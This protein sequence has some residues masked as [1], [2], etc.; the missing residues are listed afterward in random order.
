PSRF[1]CARRLGRPYANSQL[2]CLDMLQ[3]RG[4]HSCER[5]P[6]FVLNE[7]ASLGD[8]RRLTV[9][10]IADGETDGVRTDGV[11]GDLD[12]LTGNDDRRAGVVKADAR[13]DQRRRAGAQPLEE[14]SS[15]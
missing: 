10:E 15:V 7:R 14:L 3:L 5:G 6:E 8:R 9:D 13:Q 1:A 11:D 4:S 2:P 12:W